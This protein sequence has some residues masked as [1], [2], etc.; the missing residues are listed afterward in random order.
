L[1]ARDALEEG[2]KGEALLLY[3]SVIALASEHG[4]V[5]MMISG[6]LGKKGFAREALNIVAPVYNPEKHGPMA[7]L[8]LVQACIDLKHMR[9]GEEILAAIERLNRLDLKVYIE[10]LHQQLSQL[11]R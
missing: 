1:L 5:L 2:K 3:R 7:G 10:R 4:D 11:A 9:Q 8:N 6:D